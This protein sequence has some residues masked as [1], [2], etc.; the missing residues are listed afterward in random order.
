MP[1]ARK[2]RKVSRKKPAKRKTARKSG[3][4]RRPA[5]RVTKKARKRP[6]KRVAKKGRKRPAKRVAKK[7]RKRPAKRVAK[8]ARKRPAKRVAKK[9]RKRPAKRVAKKARKR[10]TKRVAKKARKRPTKRVAKKARKRPAGARTR[11]SAPSRRFPKAPAR[12]AGSSTRRFTLKGLAARLAPPV[13]P[14]IEA[15]RGGKPYAFASYSHK[16]MKEVFGVI[17]KLADSRFRVWY[18]EGIEPGNEWPEEVGKALTGCRLFLV[19]MSPAAMDSRNV[20]NEINFASAEN[21]SIMVVF[22]QPTELSEGMKLQIG[23]VQFINKYEM[24]EAE[25]VEKM[26]KVLNPDL[27][28]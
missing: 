10:P 15:Y 9:A 27:R 20:R 12:A 7:T 22:L 6:A 26:K 16:N 19:F 21:K 1:K 13:R 2:S 18:D 3:S 17:K 11:K 8:K 23:T 25:F 5:K 24:N 14:P 28:G 4:A